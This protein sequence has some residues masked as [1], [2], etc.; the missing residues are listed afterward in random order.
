MIE[1]TFFYRPV[2]LE[3]QQKGDLSVSKKKILLTSHK[4]LYDHINLIPTTFLTSRKFALRPA[5][6]PQPFCH[7]QIGGNK[8]WL[9]FLVVLFN[10]LAWHQLKFPSLQQ[11]E[12]LNYA[13]WTTRAQ[14]TLTY[15]HAV[16]DIKRVKQKKNQ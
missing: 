14:V 3:V 5:K 6:K 12:C 11:S 9:Q 2:I 13:Q 16:N 15:S 8:T 10:I 1:F 7:T 4:S